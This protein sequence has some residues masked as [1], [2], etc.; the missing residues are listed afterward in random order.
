LD[1][2]EGCIKITVLKRFDTKE[3]FKGPAVKAKYSGPFSI[4]KEG[5]VFYVDDSMP[6]QFCP[7]AWDAI[8]PLA[9]T[10]RLNG[11]F[12]EW[13]CEPGVAMAC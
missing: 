11:N 2:E 8:F 10:L 9:M 12:S 1:K 7:Y 5:H 4:F 3:V 6:S 13:Y